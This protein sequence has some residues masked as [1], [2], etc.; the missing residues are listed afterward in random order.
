MY[1]VRRGHVRSRDEDGGHTTRSAIAEN[2][3]LHADFTA[4]SSIESELLPIEVLH[5]GNRNFDVFGSRDLGLVPPND[6]QIRT[7]PVSRGDVPDERK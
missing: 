3:M 1:L 2:P 5:C 7:R 4:L 6:L